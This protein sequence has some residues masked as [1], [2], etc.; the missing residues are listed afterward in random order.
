MGQTEAPLRSLRFLFLAIAVLAVTW[1]AALSDLKDRVLLCEAIGVSIAM[2]GLVLGS[3]LG[4][5]EGYEKLFGAAITLFA[6]LA[7]F[8]A[9]QNW[10]RRSKRSK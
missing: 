3:L 5:S 1:R 9:L 6:M 8:F 4:F 7:L 10:V 2:V